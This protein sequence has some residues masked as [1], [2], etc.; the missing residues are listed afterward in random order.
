LHFGLAGCPVELDIVYFNDI[1]CWKGKEGFVEFEE[2]NGLIP[3]GLSKGFLLLVV[4]LY[5]FQ[6]LLLNLGG[7]SGKEKGGVLDT[8]VLRRG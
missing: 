2:S 5:L 7:E 1:S 8:L 4:F 6:S 3:H